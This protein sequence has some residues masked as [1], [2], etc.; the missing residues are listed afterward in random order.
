MKQSM[1]S[2]VNLLKANEYTTHSFI[3][4]QEGEIR[5]FSSLLNSILY[6]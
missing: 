1:L 6:I 3:L 2:N 5:K 4:Y